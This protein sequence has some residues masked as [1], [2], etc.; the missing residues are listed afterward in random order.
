M[1]TVIIQQVYPKGGYIN[2]IREQFFDNIQYCERYEIDYRFFWGEIK[3]VEH[4]GW[5]K[6][7]H[8]R[9][10]FSYD[11]IMWLDSDAIIK[12]PR[13]IREVP[14]PEDSIG[15]VKFMMPIPH[16]NMGVLYVKPGRRVEAFFEKWVG[17]Y[18][19]RGAWHEQEVFNRIKNECVVELPAEWNRNFDNNPF[20]NPVIMG[21]HGFGDSNNRLNLIRKV[22][23]G[24]NTSGHESL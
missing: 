24:R 8:I 4:G 19:G 23:D 7:F 17:E 20:A 10:C 18:P 9:D 11:L 5:D 22:K 16:F 21:F 3:P 2:L 15:A 6:L 1:K 14:L 13:D 12:N